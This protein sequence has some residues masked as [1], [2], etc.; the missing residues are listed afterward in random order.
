MHQAKNKT[1]RGVYL[2][3]EVSPFIYRCYSK[4]F[5]FSSKAKLE[6]FKKKL[7]KKILYWFAISKKLTKFITFDKLIKLMNWEFFQLL[8]EKTYEEMLYK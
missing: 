2:D 5:H 1:A 8:C 3:L 7:N 4:T 6:Q